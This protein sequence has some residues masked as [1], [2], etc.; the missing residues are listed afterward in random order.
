MI[1]NQGFK[2]TAYPLRGKT[3]SPGGILRTRTRVWIK[4]SVRWADKHTDPHMWVGETQELQGGFI[5]HRCAY[6]SC[7]LQG[8][9]THTYR[10]S[11]SL[12]EWQNVHGQV[13]Q[14]TNKGF[15]FRQ[16]SL[17]WYGKIYFVQILVCFFVFSQAMANQIGPSQNNHTKHKLNQAEL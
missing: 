17:W 6:R 13:Y 8:S 11:G 10:I 4:L 5:P 1:R 15:G 16:C 3:E 7:A 14:L 9:S 12:P 2:H